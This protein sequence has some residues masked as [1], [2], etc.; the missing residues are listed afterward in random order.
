M[1]MVCSFGRHIAW[2][3]GLERSH[4][5][6]ANVVSIVGVSWKNKQQ[7]PPLR[8]VP[9]DCTISYHGRPYWTKI[10]RKQRLSNACS[11][12]RRWTTTFP[13][14]PSTIPVSIHVNLIY[15]IYLDLSIF[16]C[17]FL[18]SHVHRKYIYLDLPPVFQ[19]RGRK[20]KEK[21]NRNKI[22]ISFSP[23]SCLEVLI[24]IN[25]I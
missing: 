22:D 24:N 1:L 20:K 9:M 5:N 7:S 16:P 25:I 13:A 21:R 15:S 14:K 8:C 2:Y 3:F 19:L 23:K 6:F 4:D 11:V 18:F 10:Y 12:Y 17:I